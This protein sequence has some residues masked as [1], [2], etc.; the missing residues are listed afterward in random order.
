M[1]KGERLTKVRGG[2]VSP[3]N[4][5]GTDVV[6]AGWRGGR[7]DDV[8]PTGLDTSTGVGA[9]H[10]WSKTSKPDGGKMPRCPDIQVRKQDDAEQGYN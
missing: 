10:T 3:G 6:M 8:K 7:V 1:V 5:L 9:V 4:M 2:T